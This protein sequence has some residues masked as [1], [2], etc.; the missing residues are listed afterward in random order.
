MSRKQRDFDM[1]FLSLETVKT[2]L[3]RSYCFFY[4]SFSKVFLVKTYFLYISSFILLYAKIKE[5][6]IRNKNIYNFLI[7][8]LNIL[9]SPNAFGFSYKNIC[10]L[11]LYMMI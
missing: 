4:E 8:R 10:I 5:Y 9:F 11:F 6:L 7:K 1:N 2:R 3:C